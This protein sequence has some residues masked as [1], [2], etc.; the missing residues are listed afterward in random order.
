MPPEGRSGPA[1]PLARWADRQVRSLA[2]E[3]GSAAIAALSGSVLLGERAELGGFSIP[4]RRSAGGKCHLLAT[5]DGWL[6]L[7]LA[8]DDDRDLLPA[9]FGQCM[10]DTADIGEIADLAYPCRVAE[11]VARGREMGLAIAASNET[12]ETPALE[13]LVEEP[14]VPPPGRAPLVVDLSALWAGPLCGHLLH[15]AGAQVVKVESSTRPDAMRDGDAALF[16][17][18]NGGKDNV[19]LN[20]R[21]PEGRAALLAL[22]ERADVVIEAARPRALQQM[23]IDAAALL[24]ARPGKVWVTITAHGASGAA[25]DW[26]GF[27]D[28]CG[29]AGGLSE[30]LKQASG[31][32]GFVG[33]AIADPLTGIYAARAAWSAWQSGKTCRIGLSMSGVVREAL[34]Q[35]RE[36]DEALL[37][38]ELKVWGEAAGRPFPP[39]AEREPAGPLRPLGTDNARWLPC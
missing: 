11:L 38:D 33:D 30:A 16:A 26:V 4:R 18:L 15:L 7:N 6:A 22:L 14:L 19:A 3:T 37:T 29:V 34:A 35:E 13:L 31:A 20:F 32:L 9:L 2:A 24:A 25:A 36:F 5:R 1:I 28:D 39:L 27:G 12:G 21:A 10:E 8:R 23:C 17:R